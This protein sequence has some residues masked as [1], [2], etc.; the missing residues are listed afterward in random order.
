LLLKI[1]EKEHITEARRQ[2]VEILQE[3]SPFYEGLKSLRAALSSLST[4]YEDAST[5]LRLVDEL[6]RSLETL[7]SGR[8]SL[9]LIS[10][11]LTRSTNDCSS[12]R[13]TFVDT[14]LESL[15]LLAEFISSKQNFSKM[16]ACP[17]D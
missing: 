17:T 14:D 15:R 3:E 2:V 10:L 13:S 1:S 9:K 8:R 16:I 5:A 11:M 6:R 12:M 7:K 4:F